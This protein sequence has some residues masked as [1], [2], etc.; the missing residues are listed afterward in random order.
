[1]LN[2]WVFQ[3]STATRQKLSKFVAIITRSS[4]VT[5]LH[6][7]EKEMKHWFHQRWICKWNDTEMLILTFAWLWQPNWILP[8]HYC[9]RVQRG[10]RGKGK[11]TSAPSLQQEVCTESWAFPPQ[12]WMLCSGEQA[13]CLSQIKVGNAVGPVLPPGF[14]FSIGQDNTATSS[15]CKPLCFCTCTGN[16]WNSK[17]GR[18][19]TSY[20]LY[21]LGLAQMSPQPQQVHFSS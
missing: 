11:E 19:R 4:E 5:S 14:K 2:L 13:E 7:F 9:Q 15:H 3:R 12:S 20:V 17:R 1:M 6:F 8:V 10:N 18:S 21:L 16:S